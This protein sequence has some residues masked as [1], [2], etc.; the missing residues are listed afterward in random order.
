MIPL[1]ANRSST[2]IL[3]ALAGM[4]AGNSDSQLFTVLKKVCL[5][6]HQNDIRIHFITWTGAV[7]Q[8]DEA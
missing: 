3:P 6:E 8:E 4:E 1:R 2:R 7:S 5:S